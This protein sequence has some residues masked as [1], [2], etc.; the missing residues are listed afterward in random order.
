MEGVRRPLAN[1][2]EVG[3]KIRVEKTKAISNFV[4]MIGLCGFK[5]GFDGNCRSIGCQNETEIRAILGVHLMVH[6][7]LEEISWHPQIQRSFALNSKIF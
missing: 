2:E 6:L 4:I 5:Y 3:A 7:R 1:T